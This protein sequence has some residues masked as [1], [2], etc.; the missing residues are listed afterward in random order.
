MIGDSQRIPSHFFSLDVLR[1]FAALSVVFFHWQ[2]FFYSGT[3]PGAF[4]MDKL[5]L[6]GV[7]LPLYTDGW[8]AVDLFFS[9]S[10]FVFYWL[11]ARAVAE[12][13]ITLRDFA[14]LRLSR[15]YPLHFATLLAVATGQLWLMRTTGSYFV[16][17][18]NDAEHFLLNLFFVSSW[19]FE[20]GYSFNGPV[21]SVSV[22]MLLYLAFFAYCRLF[23]VRFGM[24]LVASI[25]GFLIGYGY[26]APIGRGAGSFFLGGCV[27]LAY[28]RIVLSGGAKVAMKWVCTVTAGAW[29]ATLVATGSDLS[30]AS[31][32]FNAAPFLRGFEPH[33]PGLAP[34]LAY[35]WPT[36]ALFPLTILTL[37]LMETCR[38][39]LGRRLSFLGDISYSSYMLHFPLQ[40]AVIALV[41]SLG[42]DRSIFYSPW[43]MA[44]FF[45]VLVLVSLASHH[46]LERPAQ[47]FF[48]RHG[49]A[50]R[51]SVPV[52]V[53][54]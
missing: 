23:P 35:L 6:S 15:L 8:R 2:H 16:Y 46:L 28:Q 12:R 29:L 20:R 48:R 19:G 7:L 51:S 45:G 3:Q 53:A 54:R 52:E 43:F 49:L 21:W 17:P 11:Y 13:A 34:V 22:E 50:G 47:R 26:Y 44:S 38:R 33:L 39:S 24:L 25:I 18:E 9:L 41:V 10:G 14:V 5:P 42:D 31:L 40:L 36:V 27:F 30:V 4:A 37:A 32:L 1:G